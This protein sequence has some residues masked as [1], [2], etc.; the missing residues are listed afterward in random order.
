MADRYEL[1][2]AGEGGQGILLAGLIL[3]ESA[4]VYDDNYA[5]QTQAYGPQVRGGVSRSE[6]II[7]HQPIAYP[8]TLELDLL[9]A[10]SQEGF[11][12]YGQPRKRD[13]I[14][15]VDED[16]V[17]VHDHQCRIHALPI[18]ALA[19]AATG[20]ALTANMLGLGLVASLTN[21]VTLPALRAALRAR[22]PAHTIEMNLEALQEG[23]E[24]AAKL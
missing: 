11:N 1:R 2:L 10:L 5:V 4:T 16:R 24:Y 7:S 6:V 23:W 20:S 21:I 12:R 9:L 18:T 13:A 17:H 15:I 3:A 22:V 19:E 8:L 14:V